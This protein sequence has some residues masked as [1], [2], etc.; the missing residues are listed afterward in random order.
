[1]RINLKHGST[2]ELG[3]QSVTV[4]A[5]PPSLRNRCIATLDIE[6][7]LADAQHVVTTRPYDGCPTVVETAFRNARASLIN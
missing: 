7:C 4:Q 5:R 1:V 6:P 2:V 3:R